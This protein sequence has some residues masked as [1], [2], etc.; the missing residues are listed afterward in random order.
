MRA[1]RVPSCDVRQLRAASEPLNPNSLILGGGTF[2]FIMAFLFRDNP[3][4]DYAPELLLGIVIGGA[5]L[6]NT[7]GILCAS[8]LKKINPAIKVRAHPMALH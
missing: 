3:I 6:G 7:I 8:L 4:G 5:G 2:Y 1:A